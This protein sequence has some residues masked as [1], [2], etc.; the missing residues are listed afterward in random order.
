MISLF[1]NYLA[2]QP[3]VAVLRDGDLV[4]FRLPKENALQI[5][6][7]FRAKVASTSPGINAAFLEL[8][9]HGQGF[10]NQLPATMKTGQ[11][12]LVQV[13]RLPVGKKVAQLSKEIKIQGLHLIHIVEGNRVN[14]S[15]R[16]PKDQRREELTQALAAFPGGWIVRSAAQTLDSAAIAAEAQRLLALKERCSQSEGKPQCLYRE[17][18][19][20][21]LILSYHGEGIRSIYVDNESAYEK[22]KQ[23]LQQHF[24]QYVNL[25]Q[26]HKNDIPLFSLYKIDSQIEAALNPRVWLKTGGYLD[27][28]HS[29]A[30]T[31]IDVNSGKN[32]KKKT[33][34]SSA[35]R[36]NLEAIPF[37][38][39][40]IELRNIAGLIVIDFINCRDKN[41]QRELEMAMKKAMAKDALKCDILPVSQ[42]GLMELSR[43]QMGQSLAQ[44]I[45]ETC[46]H[47]KG[48]GWL[49][50]SRYLATEVQRQLIIEANNMKGETF[51]I[52]CGQDLG[53]YL[54]SNRPILFSAIEN[55]L[56]IKI[57]IK[58]TGPGRKFKISLS[59][60]KPKD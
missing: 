29:A 11:T 41:W 24:P 12:H 35:L 16:F 58:V 49:E 59:D 25:L 52:S 17:S 34:A 50:T 53:N 37:I 47:C 44:E 40:Q 32:S 30:L 39:N 21:Q 7:V 13:K 43:E 57:S 55:A 18:L 6:D 2:T 14:F 54:S 36:T 28:H 8:G 23:E 48:R 33:G 15:K 42:F 27:I 56:E 3:R 45:G 5:G 1:F 4:R 19:L 38:A 51:E 60:S 46:H 20:S 22:A 9:D 10:L 31:T 26:L